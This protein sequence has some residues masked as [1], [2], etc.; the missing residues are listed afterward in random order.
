ML[1]RCE[2]PRVS[3]PRHRQG[4]LALPCS[5]ALAASLC[6]PSAPA[7][8]GEVTLRPLPW[9]CATMT[10]ATS[11]RPIG[12]QAPAPV[13]RQLRKTPLWPCTRMKQTET[14]EE[15][16]RAGQG[17]RRTRPRLWLRRYCSLAMLGAG[18]KRSSRQGVLQSIRIFRHLRGLPAVREQIL[19]KRMKCQYPAAGKRHLVSYSSCKN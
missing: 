4:A 13:Q 14:A 8:R 19:L 16:C 1:C 5:L 15:R 9:R 6:G 3:D 10:W 18:A 12:V 7:G 17:R 11:S 2:K